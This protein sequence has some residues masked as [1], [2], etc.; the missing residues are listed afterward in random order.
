MIAAIAT[1][2]IRLSCVCTACVG[3]TIWWCRYVESGAYSSRFSLLLSFPTSLM[4]VSL[5]ARARELDHA[6]APVQ[7]CPSAA[8]GAAGA[9]TGGISTCE[10]LNGVTAG[11]DVLY[12]A[13]C[14]LCMLRFQ[15]YC[16]ELAVLDDAENVRITA[17]TG[18]AR[19]THTLCFSVHALHWCTSNARGRE[20][21]THSACV[22]S[23]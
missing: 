7:G 1:V 3:G 22:Y 21:H 4:Y 13:W 14:F 16:R 23:V 5:G 10:I 20:Q 19:H 6:F 2:G 12:C 8:S 11:L 15:R 9:H 18:L 17:S